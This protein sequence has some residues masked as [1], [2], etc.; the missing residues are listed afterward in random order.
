MGRNAGADRHEAFGAAPQPIAPHV[1]GLAEGRRGL[2][3]AQP[4]TGRKDCST[5]KLRKK[6]AGGSMVM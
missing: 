2:S 1:L 4:I 3:R 5:T 6:R